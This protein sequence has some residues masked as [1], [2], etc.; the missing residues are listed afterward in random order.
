MYSYQE[1]MKKQLMMTKARNLGLY[2][3]KNDENMRIYMH[4]F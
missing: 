3:L 4:V 1:S 2:V